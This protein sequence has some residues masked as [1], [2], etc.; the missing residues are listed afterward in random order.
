V[1]TIVVAPAKYSTYETQTDTLPEGRMQTLVHNAFP[2]RFDL[3]N[4]LAA[5]RVAGHF[6]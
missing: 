5:L 3:R 4:R 2:L 1:M 6:S